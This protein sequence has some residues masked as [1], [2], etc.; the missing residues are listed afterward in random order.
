MT[1]ADAAGRDRPG[2]LPASILARIHL[3]AKR[4]SHARFRDRISDW[5]GFVVVDPEQ[6]AREAEQDDEDDDAAPECP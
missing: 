1:I 5:S 3:L 2:P 6:L 4:E